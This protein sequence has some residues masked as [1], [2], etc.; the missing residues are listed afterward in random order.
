MEGRQDRRAAVARRKRRRERLQQPCI[1]F[2][3]FE[4]Q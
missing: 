2:E 1:E 3:R 4:A